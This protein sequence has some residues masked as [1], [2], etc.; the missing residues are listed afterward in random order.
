M[1]NTYCLYAVLFALMINGSCQKS[2]TV[3]D[4]LRVV[5]TDSTN[6]GLLKKQVLK[7]LP[8]NFENMFF[9]YIYDSAGR[10][11]QRYYLAKIK[12][13]N[14]SITTK[15]DTVNYHRDVLGR[16]VRIGDL[17]DS[18][19]IIV[20][21]DGQTNRVTEANDNLDSYSTQ[22]EYDANGHI[23]RLNFFMRTPTPSDPK[24]KVGYHDHVYDAQGNLIEKIF[25]QDD[26]LTGNFSSPI[27]FKFEYDN[28][29]NPRFP[30][31][32]VLFPETWSLSS[33]NNNTRQINIYTDPS[34]NMDTIKYNYIYDNKDRPVKSNK[35]GDTETAY[36]YY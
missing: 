19:Y 15:I 21:Y 24:R 6:K 4:D 10:L 2:Y 27:R 5:N 20:K 30:V 32:D 26:N 11:S 13:A 33:P 36:F 23:K 7:Y 14:G 29:I 35:N 34:M 1:R 22:F 18:V 25:Y 8:E 17:T 16:L 28:K 31:D 12:N 3:P 9:E